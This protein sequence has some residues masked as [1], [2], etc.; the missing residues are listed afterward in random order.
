[1]IHWP[2]SSDPLP[3]LEGYVH[4]WAVELDEA[5]FDARSWLG[6]LSP[7]E[8]ARAQRF[9]FA[10]DRRRYIVAHVAL[11]DILSGCLKVAAGDL[12]FVD[13]ENGK[14]RLAA[15]LPHNRLEFN[16]SHS[17]ERALVAA[18]QELV[19]GVDLEFVKSEFGF[20]EV[21]ERFFTQR[22]VSALRALPRSLQSQAFYKCWTS[23]EA[24]L[25]AKGTGL[26]GALDE[27]E[28]GLTSGNQVAINASVAGWSLM[29]LDPGDGY[30]GA[31]V[32]QGQKALPIQRHRW[33]STRWR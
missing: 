33:Q 20:H 24:F 6:R 25:K 26:S 8:Q 14:P 22:E 29:E 2:A 10:D 13:G 32:V 11:R 3:P 7:A 9:K 19:V 16:I 1:M 31:L 4:V 30:E 23:K 12:Q 27:V 18:T 5:G 28:I 21:A 17:Y 15:A